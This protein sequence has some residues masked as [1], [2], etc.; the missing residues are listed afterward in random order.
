MKSIIANNQIIAKTVRLVTDEGSNVMAIEKALAAAN[1]AGLDLI[2]VTEHDVPVVKIFDLNKFK[3]EQKQAEKAAN[4]K[5][6]QNVVLTKEI[7]FSFGTQENDLSVK[8]KSATKFLSEGKQVRVVMKQ[9]GRGSNPE[10]QK[11]NIAVMDS[12]IDRLGDVE[13]VQKVKAE[14]KNITCTV[15]NK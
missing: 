13:F 12:F 11:Q 7:Q 1:Q 15:K 3:Y 6:R 8:A 14:G 5:Q 4:K 10:L 2:Q 9:V